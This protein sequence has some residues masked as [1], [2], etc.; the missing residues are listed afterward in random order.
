MAIEIIF[1]P[2]STDNPYELARRRLVR[3]LC[4]ISVPRAGNLDEVPGHI[5]EVAAACD[6]WAG[7]I[8]HQVSDLSPIPLDYRVFDAPFTGAVEGE[9]TYIAEQAAEAVYLVD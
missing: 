7:S 3:A 8:G 5:R 9:G 6:N 4:A 1:I 2:G